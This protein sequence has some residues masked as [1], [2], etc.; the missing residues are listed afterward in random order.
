[1]WLRKVQVRSAGLYD[2]KTFVELIAAYG[3][4]VES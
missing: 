4:V 3:E 1:M 2:E